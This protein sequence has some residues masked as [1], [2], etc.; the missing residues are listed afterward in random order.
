MQRPNPET[1]SLNDILITEELSQRSP[2]SPNLQAENQALRSLARQMARDSEN[3]LQTLTDTALEL[4]QAG[5]AGVSLLETTPDGEEIF[6]WTVL[7]GT[8]AHHVGGTSFRNF[9][10]CGVCLDQGTPVLFPTPND[11]S[12]TSRKR[13][14]PSW[15]G[16]C[17]PWLLITMPSAQSGLCRTMRGGS[18]T[19]KTCES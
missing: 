7:A 6:R 15:K 3:L 18:L 14:P 19:Q 5:T 13:I 11:I 9:S 2:R 1:T 4:C 17:C 10:P 12:P 16:W 8:L